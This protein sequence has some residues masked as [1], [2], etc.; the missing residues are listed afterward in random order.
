MKKIKATTLSQFLD[1]FNVQKVRIQTTV[2]TKE[3]KNSKENKASFVLTEDSTVID[4][5]MPGRC[6]IGIDGHVYYITEPFEEI[7][8]IVE[9]LKTKDNG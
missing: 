7:Y 4:G 3:G 1:S 2:I 6:F 5:D 9:S 8:N